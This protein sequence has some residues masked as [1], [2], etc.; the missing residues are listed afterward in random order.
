MSS[1][2]S[3]KTCFVYCISYLTV[4]VYVISLILMEYTTSYWEIS[5]LLNTSGLQFA[6]IYTPNYWQLPNAALIC[7]HHAFVFILLITIITQE[8]FLTC[9][10]VPLFLPARFNQW[11]YKTHFRGATTQEATLTLNMHPNLHF[12][13]EN[14]FLRVSQLRRQ[15][16]QCYAPNSNVGLLQENVTPYCH[17]PT[18]NTSL[19]FLLCLLYP[20]SQTTTPFSP[21]N[22]VI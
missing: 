4:L 15:L 1:Y 14:V 7:I 22:D 9:H 17:L 21:G 19:L 13:V 10:L 18:E 3:D 20:N 11:Q 2:I 8:Y 16:V 12:H 6:L 5:Y